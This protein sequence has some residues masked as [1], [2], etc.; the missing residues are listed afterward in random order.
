M[1]VDTTALLPTPEVLRRLDRRVH[2]L[3][4][5]VDSEIPDGDD[6]DFVDLLNLRIECD[7]ECNRLV[8]SLRRR[9]LTGGV[10][11]TDHAAPIPPARAAS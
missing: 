10:D 8:R 1:T 9:D 5:L 7:P 6:A 4:L 2:T 3:Y 11:W